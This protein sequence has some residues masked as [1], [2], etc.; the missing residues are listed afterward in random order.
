MS[1]GEYV[2]VYPWRPDAWNPFGAEV[3]RVWATPRG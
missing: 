2:H 3:K 1:V